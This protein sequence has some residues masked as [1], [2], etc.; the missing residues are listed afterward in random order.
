MTFREFIVE[1]ETGNLHSLG[2]LV[3][4]E[5]VRAAD[6]KDRA[7]NDYQRYALAA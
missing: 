3:L 2:H 5:F 6:M 1:V 4:P 7:I